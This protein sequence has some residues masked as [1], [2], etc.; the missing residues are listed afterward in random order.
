MHFV[1]RASSRGALTPTTRF[2]ASSFMDSLLLSNISLRS[3]F[4]R[5]KSAV[6]KGQH[7][8]FW[9]SGT[10]LISFRGYSLTKGAVNAPCLPHLFTDYSVHSAQRPI[11]VRRDSDRAPDQTT[12]MLS[13]PSTTT[14]T[15]NQSVLVITALNPW[16]TLTHI[17]IVEKTQQVVCS[18]QQEQH[19]EM[20]C[21]G[22]KQNSAMSL[23]Q[24]VQPATQSMQ[25]VSCLPSVSLVLKLNYVYKNT[26]QI[27]AEMV[28]RCLPAVH[29]CY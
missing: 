27:F 24:P 6:V 4:L 16:L 3:S 21:S 17:V 11:G 26:V 7:L 14:T 22:G 18:T 9:L 20:S 12:G 29:C 8:T 23:M 15:K 1:Q 10:W 28:V 19:W 5:T 25:P 2:M 13:S